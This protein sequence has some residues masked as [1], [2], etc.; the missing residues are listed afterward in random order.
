VAEQHDDRSPFALAV[1]WTSRITTISLEMVIPT[2]LGY[3]LDQRWNTK[4][5]CLVIGAI[6]GFATAFTS[7][8]RLAKSSDRKD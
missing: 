3:W 5:L 6:L 2:V 1:E 8:L 7:L 4:F